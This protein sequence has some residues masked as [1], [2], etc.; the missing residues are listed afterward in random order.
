MV[1]K[2]IKQTQ[3]W[4]GWFIRA[5]A[6][7]GFSIFS[8]ALISGYSTAACLQSLT[9][10]GIYLFAEAMKYYQLEIPNKNNYK[11]LVF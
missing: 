10:A 9:L 11:F 8:N 7:F 3:I 4:K 2:K 6:I 5:F 1:K